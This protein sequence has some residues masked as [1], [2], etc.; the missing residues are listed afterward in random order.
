[1]QGGV[2]INDPVKT[3]IS[4]GKYLD[5]NRLM[6][7]WSVGN[8]SSSLSKMIDAGGMEMEVVMMRKKCCKV[9]RDARQ[10][11]PIEREGV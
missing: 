11:R 1:M 9:W 6:N 2:R 10:S 4:S 8:S 3:A 5:A 7:N